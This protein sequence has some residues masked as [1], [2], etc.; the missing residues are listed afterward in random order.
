MGR[1]P[2]GGFTCLLQN[3]KCGYKVSLF[4]S[5]VESAK[6]VNRMQGPSIC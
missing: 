6:S 5:Y 4:G 1:G 3:D 2:R